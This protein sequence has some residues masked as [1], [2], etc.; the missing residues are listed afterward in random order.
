LRELIAWLP[1]P[2]V[3][4]DTEYL[5]VVAG[6]GKRVITSDEFLVAAHGADPVSGFA[7]PDAAA[8]VLFTSG[9][10]SRPKAVELSHHNLTSY[11][12]GTVD[13]ASAEGVMVR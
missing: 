10:T 9:T 8:V 4:A 12:T 2:L 13:F 1:T 3:V 6:S 7:D 11:V 5:D